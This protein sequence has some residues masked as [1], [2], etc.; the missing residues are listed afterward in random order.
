MMD[1]LPTRQLLGEAEADRLSGVVHALLTELA[2][3]SERVAALEARHGQDVA[4]GAQ[5][6]IDELTA[7][8]LHPLLSA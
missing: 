2:V 6:R 4:S 5:Q 3:L 1:N 7:R 8:T